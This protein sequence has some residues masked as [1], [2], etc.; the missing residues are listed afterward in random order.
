VDEMERM[1]SFATSFNGDLSNFDTSS[2]TDMNGMFY[3]AESFNRDLS[4]FDTSSVTDMSNMFQFAESFNQ[5]VS[6]FVISKATC[7]Y[8]MFN[9]ASSFNQDLCLWQD[10]FPYTSSCVNGDDN[11]FIK[12]GC[13][14]KTTPQEAQK[15]PFCASDCL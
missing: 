9:G 7:V 3:D 8:L 5:D 6:N 1:F 12:S 10:E 14:Y 4:N 15:G 2:V 13:T 11:I